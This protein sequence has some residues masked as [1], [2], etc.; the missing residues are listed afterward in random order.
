VTR[1][2]LRLRPELCSESTAL[3]A[4]RDFP[5]LIKLLGTLD[6]ALGGSLSSFEVMWNNFYRAVLNQSS[7]H[8]APLPEEYP[9]YVLLEAQGADAKSDATRFQSALERAFESGLGIRIL[10]LM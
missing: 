8:Q 1:A 2:V 7:R 10:P 9:Y 5:S 4:V 3:L 6:Q